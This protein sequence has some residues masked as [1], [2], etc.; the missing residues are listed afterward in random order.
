MSKSKHLTCG[1]CV[2]INVTSA[3]YM[4]IFGCKRTGYVIP[5]EA[6]MKSEK[7]TFWRVPDFCPRSDDEVSKSDKLAPRSEW[8]IKKFTDFDY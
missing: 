4:P 2:D 3:M 8:I 7:V 1:D 6:V 5:H